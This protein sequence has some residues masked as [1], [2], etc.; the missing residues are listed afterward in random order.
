MK[1]PFLLD[2]F[3]GAGGA[4]MGYHRAGF[5]IVGVDNQ[6]QPNYPYEF[7]LSDAMTYPLEG[8]DVIHASPPCQR[9]SSASNIGP[10]GQEDTAKK[11]VDLVAPT[12]DR[13]KKQQCVYVI[14]NVPGAPLLSPIILCG[15]MFGLRLDDGFYSGQLRRHRLF[16]SNVD[17]TTPQCQHNEKAL[18]VFGHGGSGKRRTGKGTG[19]ISL[20]AQSARDIMQI[21]WMNRN[22]VAQAIPPAFTEYIGRQLMKVLE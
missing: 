22:E 14:E 18:G 3:C 19:G 7:H 13:L 15:S 11:Y 9:F 16:E 21:D 17:L 5:E 12:R 20:P 6:P 1:R 8:F 10:E 4:A 2:L